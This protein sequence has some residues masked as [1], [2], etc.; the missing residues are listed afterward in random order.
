MGDPLL[1]RPSWQETWDELSSPPDL[2]PG[3]EERFWSN[4]ERELGAEELRR[5]ESAQ[6]LTWWDQLW[7]LAWARWTP[8]AFAAALVAVLWLPTQ[9]PH[10]PPAPSTSPLVQNTPRPSAPAV[11]KAPELY[12]KLKMWREM[13]VLE[14]IE[15]LEK[16][17]ELKKGT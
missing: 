17:P 1:N 12:S 8:A 6:H 4:F 14:N 3:M 15:V 11:Q 9:F 13:E 10:T 16:L 5:Q 7:S 2:P